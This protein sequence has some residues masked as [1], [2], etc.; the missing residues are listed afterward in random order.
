MAIKAR[1]LEKRSFDSPDSVRPFEK[2][3]IMKSKLGDYV[4]MI[5]E[6]E[7]GWKW[8]EHVKGFARTPSCQVPHVGV[9][10]S[11][12][13]HFLMD[14]GTEEEFGPGDLYVIPGG[15]DA[16]VVGDEI[17]RTVDFVDIEEDVNPKVPQEHWSR[18]L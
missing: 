11:G 18:T 3:K 16:W 8:S 2:S 9:M 5:S 15:Y 10:L 14:D 12:R 4:F 1:Q 13:L 17:A 7:P 6:F